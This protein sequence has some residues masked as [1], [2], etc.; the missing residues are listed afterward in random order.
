MM[1]RKG[2]SLPSNAVLI[3]LEL[4]MI[5]SDGAEDLRVCLATQLL[6]VQR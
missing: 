6:M 4:I 3:G 1:A 2:K 5:Y